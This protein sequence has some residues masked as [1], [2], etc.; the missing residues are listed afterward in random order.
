M[1][2]LLAAFGIKDIVYG[3]MIVA[4]LGAAAYERHHLIVEGEADKMAQLASS[5]KKLLD[6]NAAKLEK[7]READLATIN[8]IETGYNEALK[9]SVASNTNLANRLRDYEAT[10]SSAG[11]VQGHT[12]G[13]SRPASAAPVPGSVDEAVGGVIQAAGHDADQ[14]KALQDYITKE[15]K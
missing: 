13:V 3:T 10:R 6:A 4:L 15:C 14:V 2:A 5:T 7:Q 12:P 9:S 1:G 11:A 8:S